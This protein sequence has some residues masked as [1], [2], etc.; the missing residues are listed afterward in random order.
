MQCQT[1]KNKDM[2]FSNANTQNYK[3]ALLTSIKEL[4][5]EN[6]I[7]E[8]SLKDTIFEKN[9]EWKSIIIENDEL[10][11]L[12]HPSQFINKEWT[13]DFEFVTPRDIAN[14]QPVVL[15]KVYSMFI[16]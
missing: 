2:K 5:L 10:K 8:V 7:M 1:N 4:M 16:L 9:G 13:H 3:K 6:N 12:R 14:L 15:N 11:V